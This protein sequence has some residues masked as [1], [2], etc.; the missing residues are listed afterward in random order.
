MV[1]EYLDL[2]DNQIISQAGDTTIW[3]IV[4]SR[5]LSICKF[6]LC[7]YFFKD[8]ILKSGKNVTWLASSCIL[9]FQSVK[10]LG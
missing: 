9:K 6:P 2:I 8:V 1:M 4:S 10:L 3:K 5:L 7:E